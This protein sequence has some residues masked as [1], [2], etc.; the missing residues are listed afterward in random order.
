MRSGNSEEARER[1]RR[2][3]EMG[4][5]RRA[6]GLSCWRHGRFGNQDALV[7]FSRAFPPLR[8]LLRHLRHQSV[9]E[10]TAIAAASG[11]VAAMGNPVAASGP[12][13]GC[14]CGSLHNKQEFLL[15]AGIDDLL[16]IYNGSG[17]PPRE[18]RTWWRRS[19]PPCSNLSPWTPREEN[20]FTSCCCLRARAR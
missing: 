14:G 10:C 9:D 6:R 12:G 3:P 15:V 2:R 20:E 13:G 18:S 5:T 16:V 1:R 19:S 4:K 7:L 8:R 11:G 17:S